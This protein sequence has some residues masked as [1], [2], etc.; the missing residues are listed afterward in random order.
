MSKTT[1][2]EQSK[3]LAK[4]RVWIAEALW[5]APDKET[6]DTLF[7]AQQAIGFS[8]LCLERVEYLTRKNRSERKQMEPGDYSSLWW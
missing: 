4:I 5:D 6:Q 8:L 7:E 2:E 3:N 1:L